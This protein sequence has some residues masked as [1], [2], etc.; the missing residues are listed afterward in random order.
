MMSLAELMNCE[1]TGRIIHLRT[2][3]VLA[4]VALVSGGPFPTNVF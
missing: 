3:S 4:K 1:E 2:I